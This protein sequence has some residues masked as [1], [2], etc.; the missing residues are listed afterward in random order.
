[1]KN[2]RRV[3]ESQSRAELGTNGEMQEFWGIVGEGCGEA[4][5]TE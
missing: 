3:A 4:A 2:Y 5:R 1:M